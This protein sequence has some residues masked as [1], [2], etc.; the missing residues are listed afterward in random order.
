MLYVFGNQFGARIVKG[1]ALT[2]GVGVILS[3]FTAF[4]VARTFMRVLL[5]NRSQRNK[6]AQAIVGY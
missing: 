3:M 5:G 1:Y 4:V 2:L 6:A